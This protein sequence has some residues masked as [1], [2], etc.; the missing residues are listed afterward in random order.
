MMFKDRVIGLLGPDDRVDDYVK[1]SYECVDERV[2][3]GVTDGEIVKDFSM[4]C[5]MIE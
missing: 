3:N 5:E 1:H 2:L 4:Y